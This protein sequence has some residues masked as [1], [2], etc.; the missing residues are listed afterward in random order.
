M[1][2]KAVVFGI[3]GVATATSLSL[4]FAFLRG[5]AQLKAWGTVEVREIHVG[6]TRWADGLG[7]CW[8]VKAI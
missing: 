5:P 3:V 1:N 8:C 2:K 7:K 4:Y 6:S